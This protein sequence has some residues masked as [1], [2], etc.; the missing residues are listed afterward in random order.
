MKNFIVLILLLFSAGS[1][2]QDSMRRLSESGQVFKENPGINYK[3]QRVWYQRRLGLDS[4]TAMKLVKAD[5][6][7]ENGIH[8]AFENPSF[9]VMSRASTLKELKAKR[10]A[11]FKTVLTSEQFSR[12]SRTNKPGQKQSSPVPHII[13]NDADK[14]RYLFALRQEYSKTL[15]TLL[16]DNKLD[17]ISKQQKLK[18]LR[19]V[20]DTKLNAYLTEQAKAF[21]QRRK[22]RFSVTTAT[23]QNAPRIPAAQNKIKPDENKNN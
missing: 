13:R 3:I 20:Q 19:E 17:S 12:L 18:A 11:I 4:A 15:S 22:A 5:E 10:D 14:N 16:Q 2:G 23:K 9:D 1:Y 6:D 8:S 7:K 21:E